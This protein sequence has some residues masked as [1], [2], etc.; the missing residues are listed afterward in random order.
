MSTRHRSKKARA[1]ARLAKRTGRGCGSCKACCVALRI[2]QLDKP[3]FQ[4]CPHLSSSGCAIY[5]RRPGDCRAYECGWRLGLGA[6][7]DAFPWHRPDRLGAFIEET[8]GSHGRPVILFRPLEPQMAPTRG[9]FKAMREVILDVWE[10]LGQREADV[11]WEPRFR[12]ADPELTTR[13]FF[14]FQPGFTFE[15]F[16]EL[17][18]GYQEMFTESPAEE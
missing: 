11:A 6:G 8:R 10:R 4:D 14:I 3:P 13:P 15:K 2:V 16:T 12:P 18:G 7:D 17:I 5:G 9:Q 1:S